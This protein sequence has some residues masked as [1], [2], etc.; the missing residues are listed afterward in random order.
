LPDEL[1]TAIALK[2]L[3]RVPLCLYVMDDN[4]VYAH[5]IPDELMREAVNKADLRLA[6]SPEMR[7]AYELKYNLKFWVVPPVVSPQS[8][9]AQPETRPKPDPENRVGVLI[10]NV[11][12]RR[13][14]ERL[15]QTVRQAGTELHW[16]GNATAP[17]LK[18]T[19]KELQQDG[20]IDCGFLPE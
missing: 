16:Y 3:F 6:I 2:E 19:A 12:S 17:W 10:G 8:L 5:G 11:W 15:R 1:I 18:V 7:D 9:R 13:W 20:I 4:N 14:L